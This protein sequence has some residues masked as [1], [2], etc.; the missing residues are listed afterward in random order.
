MGKNEGEIENEAR[1][2]RAWRLRETDACTNRASQNLK[3]REPGGD[4]HVFIAAF[5]V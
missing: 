4:M 1:K 2:E 5:S 3:K